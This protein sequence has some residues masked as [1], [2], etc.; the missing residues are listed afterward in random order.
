MMIPMRFTRC[1]GLRGKS[2]ATELNLRLMEKVVRVRQ[3]AANLWAS[4]WESQIAGWGS[5]HRIDDAIDQFLDDYRQANGGKR[6]R[7]STPS[8]KSLD[9]S[10]GSVFRMKLY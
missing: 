2:S 8:N 5:S 7:Q 9:A 1:I 3:P 6:V 4:T 10:R